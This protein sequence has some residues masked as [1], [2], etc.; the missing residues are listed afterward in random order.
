MYPKGGRERGKRELA[1]DCTC[2]RSMH[3]IA[4]GYNT[5]ER[6]VISPQSCVWNA[7]PWDIIIIIII[8]N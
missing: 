3:Q 7:M 1:A 5:N 8:R 2:A 6:Q 4:M